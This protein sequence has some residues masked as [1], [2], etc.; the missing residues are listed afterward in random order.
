MRCPNCGHSF[1]R[2]N[3]PVRAVNPTGYNPLLVINPP[4]QLKERI[5]IAACLGCGAMFAKEFQANETCPI[6]LKTVGWKAVGEVEAP[7]Q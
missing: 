3:R 5:K 1:R 4:P 6:C 7:I 2:R